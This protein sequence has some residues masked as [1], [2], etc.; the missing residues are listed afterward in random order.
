[1]ESGSLSLHWMR[2]RARPEL[3]GIVILAAMA[4]L[5]AIGVAIFLMVANRPPPRMV[6]PSP[7]RMTA[8]KVPHP[9]GPV[10]PDDALTE[11]LLQPLRA[12]PL[13]RD[14]A[15]AYNATV[16]ISTEPNPAAAIFR[17]DKATPVDIQRATD[18]LTAAIYFEA[19]L[20][21]ASGQRAVAQVVLNRV[22]HF[23]FPKTVC[24][25]VFQGSDRPNG[26]QF[27]FTCDGSMA[28]KIDQDLWERARGTALA[29]LGGHVEPRIGHATHYHAIYVAPYWQPSLLKVAKVGLHAFYRGIGNWGLPPSFTAR[30]VGG[31]PDIAAMTMIVPAPVLPPPL[32]VPDTNVVAPL[33]APL[34][35]HAVI[36]EM[37]PA[38]P[39]AEIARSPDTP[40]PVIAPR[41]SDKP[42]FVAPRPP[43]TRR[44]PF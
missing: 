13:T 15:V 43:T 6:T 37:Q 32:I 3:L 7:A 27:T 44:L 22:R 25:V 36:P 11:A 28:K 39:L 18:C 16:P 42:A 4:M 41:S 10:Q 26:C 31:E 21:P 40:P 23:A 1:M 34:S 2:I 33:P 35:E 14:Q 12:Q 30:Y 38:V 20:E 29:A 9:D 17:L 8:D 5:F 24:G 19:A